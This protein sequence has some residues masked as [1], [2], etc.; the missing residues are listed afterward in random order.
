MKI[1]NIIFE[2]PESDNELFGR[3]TWTGQIGRAHV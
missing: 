2:N 3:P 1:K